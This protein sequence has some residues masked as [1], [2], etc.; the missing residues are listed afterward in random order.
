MSPLPPDPYKILGVS[1]D[2]QIPEIRSA[3]RKLVLQ[4]HPDKVQD[5]KLK[6]EKADQFQRVQQAY[7]L[8]TDDTERRKYDDKAKVEELRKQVHTKVHI[9]TP[10]Q[11]SRHNSADFDT[12]THSRYPSRSAAD[13][14]P[15]A[16]RMYSYT[17]YYDDEYM[18]GARIFEATRSSKRE[19]SDKPSKRDME[20]EKDRER[21]KARE[22]REAREEEERRIEKQERRERAQQQLKENLRAEK[23]AKRTEKRKKEKSRSKDIKR[24]SEDKYTRYSKLSDEGED[25]V[26]SKPERKRS[27]GPINPKKYDDEYERPRDEAA[28]PPPVSRPSMTTRGYSNV[29][30]QAKHKAEMASSYIAK[31]IKRSNSYAN[32]HMPPPHAPT[33][34]TP[35]KASAYPPPTVEDYVPS[36]E[37]I[38]RSSAR[39]GSAGRSRE[40]STY[41]K[42][43]RDVLDDP[44]PASSSP[45]AR[46]I[47]SLRKTAPG[48]TAH[49][50]SSPPW[51]LPRSQTMPVGVALP[52]RG[53][54]TRSNT[55]VPNRGRYRTR[56]DL[57]VEEDSDDH[58]RRADRKSRRSRRTHSPEQIETRYQVEGDRTYV[59]NGFS[60]DYAYPHIHVSET[61]HPHYHRDA[62][63]S[64]SP[65]MSNYHKIHYS[66]YG[67]MY[68]QRAAM[69]AS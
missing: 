14:P 48:T 65:N 12:R 8:L 64:S 2:A 36:D 60:E 68:Q 62:S 54:P 67:E 15:S 7:E 42:S 10:R 52:P 9:S 26:T 59:I 57:P 49:M 40:R 44:I 37:E 20:K 38:R 32:T 34:P 61:R 6:A 4:C 69:P 24:E 43:S 21:R 13:S 51:E 19:Y 45:A 17:A 5:P 31:T 33:P 18:P 50:S 27:S 56:Y 46:S 1:K 25:I 41:R 58:D 3:H 16:T 30:T 39:R 35:A 29:E 66:D 47:P 63:Y 23:E 53:P 11:S 22:A 55:D 28:R